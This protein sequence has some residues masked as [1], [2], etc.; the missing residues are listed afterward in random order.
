MKTNRFEVLSADEIRRI[1]NASLEISGD[2]GCE[3]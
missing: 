3:M 2:G 1:H